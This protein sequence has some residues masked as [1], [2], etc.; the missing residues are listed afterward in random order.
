MTLTTYLVTNTRDLRT[1]YTLHAAI[2]AATENADR[3]ALWRKDGHHITIDTPLDPTPAGWRIT[4]RHSTPPIA[5][6]S[7][8]LVD[9]WLNPVVT[10]LRKRHAIPQHEQPAWA[11][12]QLERVGLQPLTEVHAIAARK[13]TGHRDGSGQLTL[14]ATRFQATATV[15]DPEALRE[16]LRVGVGHGKA[17]GLG[18]LTLTTP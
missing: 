15:T 14:H 10:R 2:Q 11:T 5:A 9:A 16:A 17:F 3:R 12:R 7:V 4:N 6:S 1:D 18:L 8:V 13:V